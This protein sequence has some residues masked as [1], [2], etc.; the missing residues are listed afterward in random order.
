[1]AK[2]R[3]ARSC[4]PSPATIGRT[5]VW[6]TWWMASVAELDETH[7]KAIEAG[8]IVTMPPTNKPWGIRE[9]HLRH[10]DGHMFRV[11]AGLK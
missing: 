5:G 3:A 1:M 7:A 4:R 2:A 11:S 10:P 9:F 6:M 8:A